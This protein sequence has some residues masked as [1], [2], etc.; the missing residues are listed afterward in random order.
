M[1]A[2]ETLKLR[3]QRTISMGDSSL[4]G[5]GS[6]T[7]NIQGTSVAVRSMIRS[8]GL[9]VLFGLWSWH[10]TRYLITRNTSIV[11]K[12]PPYQRTAAG[13]V[14][15]DFTLNDKVS[16]P[17]IIP[18]ELLKWTGC[19]LPFLITVCYA[20]WSSRWSQKALCWLEVLTAVASFS[21]AIGLS[22]GAT[23]VLKIWV[24]RRR[25]SFYDLCGFNIQTLQ[26]EA[27]ADY[28]KEA[29]LS[30]PSGHSSMSCCGMTFL[31]WYF[32]GKIKSRE[33]WVTMVIAVV[34]WGWAIFVAASRLVDHWHHPSD[35]VAGLGLGF[36]T[37]TIAY[38]VWYPPVWSAS[39]GIARPVLE[40]F[41]SS[42]NQKLSSFND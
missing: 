25:P 28:I 40:E 11:S 33:R 32:Q 27:S 37:S 38:H 5:N 1:D 21:M 7:T 30:F 26:C 12:V 10:Y 29:N 14:I 2:E 20:Y 9:W 22:E 4:P 24:Q 17:P 6:S 8:A 19:Y 36:A 15:L 41:D 31:V 13:D 42:G 35:I 34:P 23:N 3:L 39:A 18:S 16:D